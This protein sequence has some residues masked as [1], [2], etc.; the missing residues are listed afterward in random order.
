[1][2]R[3]SAIVEDSW[4]TLLQHDPLDRNNIELS[5]DSHTTDN[6]VGEY[7]TEFNFFVQLSAATLTPVEE[8][9]HS[10]LDNLPN[11]RV[12][13]ESTMALSLNCTKVSNGDSTT[14][15]KHVGTTPPI[16]KAEKEALR[17]AGKAALLPPACLRSAARPPCPV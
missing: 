16:K 8:V 5:N 4:A 7:C 17:A 1:M 15:T 11:V 10:P 14:A 12:S 13:L 3:V 6:G 2:D 9:V